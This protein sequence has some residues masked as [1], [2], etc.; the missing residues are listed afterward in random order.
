V[1][2]CKKMTG[3]GGGGGGG[4]ATVPEEGEGMALTA[5]R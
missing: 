4:A 2:F 1:Q 3:G 5:R